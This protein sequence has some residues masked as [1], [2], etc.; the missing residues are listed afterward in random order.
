MPR[1]FE[2][3][4]NGGCV[5]VGSEKGVA[6]MVIMRADH[7]PLR[8]ASAGSRRDE[9]DEVVADL[10]CDRLS[11]AAKRR[12]WLESDRSKL[13]FK[14]LGGLAIAWRARLTAGLLGACQECH[15]TVQSLGGDRVDGQVPRIDGIHRVEAAGGVEADQK[16]KS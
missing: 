11:I 7:Q 3:D 12:Q 5:V 2:K 13:V 1:G 16:G 14:I 15:M 6:K 8:R 4:G 10:G 9:T